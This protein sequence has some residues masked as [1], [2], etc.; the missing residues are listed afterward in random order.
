MGKV[1]R[2]FDGK[3]STAL[4]KPLHHPQ[5]DEAGDLHLF[6]RELAHFQAWLSKTESDIA[7]EDSPSNLAEVEKL[8]STH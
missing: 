5:V 6:L 8:L 3:E 7:N 1:Q 2:S 4:S